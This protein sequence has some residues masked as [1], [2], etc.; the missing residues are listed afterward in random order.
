LDNLYES[1]TNG[2]VHINQKLS[3]AFYREVVTI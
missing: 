2:Q 1:G 3:L